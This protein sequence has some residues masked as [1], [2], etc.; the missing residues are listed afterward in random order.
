V[1]GAGTSQISFNTPMNQLHDL[2]LP[3]LKVLGALVV[4]GYAGHQIFRHINARRCRRISNYYIRLSLEKPD[5]HEQSKAFRR[6]IYFEQLAQWW[7]GR[8]TN[9]PT[10]PDHATSKPNTT[11]N[12]G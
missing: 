10:E 9:A 7:E 6:G 2:A 11:Q 12:Q 8:R 1:E 4:I 5:L 3:I